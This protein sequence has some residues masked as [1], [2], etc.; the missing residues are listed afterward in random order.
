MPTT[1]EQLDDWL[2]AP[3]E[4]EHLEFKA[5]RGSYEFDR[6]VEYC[7]ALANEGGGRIVL[8]VTDK[9]P[10][11]VVGT[12]AFDEIERTK[13]GLFQQLHL[14]VDAEEVQHPGGRVLV[15][16][17]PSRPVGT[18]VEHKGRYLMRVGE[19]VQPMSPDQ[20]R[21]IMAEAVADFSAE[22]CDGAD[23]SCLDPEAVELLRRAWYSRS[24]NERLL[25]L[26]PEQLLT[27]AGLLVEGCATNAALVLLAD[28]RTLR[29]HQLGQAEVIFE[30]RMDPDATGYDARTT[31]QDGFLLCA[32][33]I[34]QQVALRNEVYGIQD[35]LFR[36]E[37]P[38]FEERVVREALVNAV[39]HRDYRLGASVFVY[40]S[41]RRL[42]V[43]SPGGFL[44]GVG[45]ENI[46]SSHAWRNRLIAETLEKCGYV[47]RSGQ[48]VN[49]MFEASIRDAKLP[50]DY[51][52]SDAH[53]VR[54]VLSGQ[55]QDESFVRFLEEVGAETQRSFSTEDYI[56][57]DHL[58]RA[59][60]VPEGLDDRLSRLRDLGVIEKTGPGRARYV[61][62]RRYYEFVG[63]AGEYT[64]TRGLNRETNKE[65]LLKHITD[66]AAR[67]APLSELREVLPDLTIPQVRALVAELKREGRVHPVGNTRG[68]RWYPGRPPIGS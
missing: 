61:L 17:V 27:D 16:H 59:L 29:R 21:S 18:A 62:S 35:G 9:R 30:F 23:I 52:A 67:G 44:P 40:Q 32:D 19:Q 26:S 51:T 57:L 54:V 15:F 66:S 36:R 56:V 47:E 60:R 41:P 3:S 49:L 39:A 25:T 4:T 31:F 34:W 13:A 5:A 8:G 45:P 43:E 37:I 14:R 46:L 12:R 24:G 6:L 63:K 22:T 42:L 58:R 33:S 1:V 10:R 2:R 64:R 48:G 11:T 7:V 68:A 20:L 38:S 53:S 65:L 28:A 50:P 55:V